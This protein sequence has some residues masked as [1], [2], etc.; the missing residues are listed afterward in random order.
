MPIVSP[1]R[2]WPPH[3]LKD[4]AVGPRANFAPFHVSFV[5]DTTLSFL[6]ARDGFGV[7]F[8]VGAT[9]TSSVAFAFWTGEIWSIDTGL[10][11]SCPND[12]PQPLLEKAFSEHLRGYALFLQGLGINPPYCWVAGVTDVNGRRLELP[13]RS[14]SGPLC[15]AE[16]ITDEGTY[17]LEQKPAAASQPFFEEI[18]AECGMPRRGPG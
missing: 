10:L 3:K 7:Y 13:N 17:D 5:R 4:H 2:T 18:F 9:E 1:G 11:A 16:T 8:A 14:F 6:R 15:L 12:L